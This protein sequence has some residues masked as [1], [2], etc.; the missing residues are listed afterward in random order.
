MTEERGNAWKVTAIG[1]AVVFL[2]ALITGLVVAN[3]SGQERAKEVTVAPPRPAPYQAARPSASDIRLCNQY[4]RGAAGD[5]TAEVV[6]DALI[7]GAVGASVGAAS[8]AIAG[9][10]SGAGKGAG[11][12]SLV[13]ATAGTLY[14]LNDVKQ[15][16]ARHADAYRAC[17]KRRG[18][19]E[20]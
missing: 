16:D 2:T 5:K 3:W 19:T 10:G 9:G 6:K 1:M 11:I 7:G 18:F 4:A 17:M 20:R 15:N 12:G 14:S 13:G 8:G